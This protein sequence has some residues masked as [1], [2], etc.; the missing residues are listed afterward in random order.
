[1]TD[2]TQRMPE[3]LSGGCMCGAVRHRILRRRSPEAF[4]LAIDAGRNPAA[5]SQP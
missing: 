4:A 3:E 5:L 2:E 1:M